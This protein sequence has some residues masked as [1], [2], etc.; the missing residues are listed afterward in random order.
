MECFDEED[1]KGI[2]AVN[3][4]LLGPDV[5]VPY[6]GNV[7]QWNTIYGGL[8]RETLQ[9]AR[10]VNHTGFAPFIRSSC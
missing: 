3:R 7:V 2:S 4:A 1:R 5:P 10:K 8:T 6:N 9:E